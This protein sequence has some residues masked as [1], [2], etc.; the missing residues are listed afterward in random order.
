V[1]LIPMQPRSFDLWAIDQMAELV[2]EA[3]ELNLKLRAVLVIN[4]A[5]PQGSDN[6]DAA[7]AL[8]DLPNMTVLPITIGRR[9]A[10]PNAAA[11]GRAVIESGRDKDVKA[12]TELM[13]LVQALY[14]QELATR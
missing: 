10:F 5:D 9:K 6:Q 11:A 7:A 13:D 14:A 2:S 12:A 8:Q 1:V 4:A 3:R